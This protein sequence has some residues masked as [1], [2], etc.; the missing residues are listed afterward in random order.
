[1]LD[2]WGVGR[3]V[4]AAISVRHGTMPLVNRTIVIIESAPVDSP[5]GNRQGGLRCMT[6]F[7]VLTHENGHKV[8]KISQGWVV[9]GPN[10]NDGFVYGA[11]WAAMD[12]AAKTPAVFVGK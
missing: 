12:A 7:P 6:L 11:M 9:S 4:A 2:G 1:M 8:K 10:R 3:C 5:S